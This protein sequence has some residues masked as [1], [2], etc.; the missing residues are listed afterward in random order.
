MAD[1]AITPTQLGRNAG[2]VAVSSTS[3]ATIV[4][5]GGATIADCD[6]DK[7]VLVF[8][9][10]AAATKDVTAE[11]GDSIYPAVRSGQ[12]DLVVTMGANTGSAVLAG[13]DS[14]R[15]RKADGSLRFTLASGTTGT[16]KAFYLP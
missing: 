14:G 16:V 9:N 5:A 1:T 7:L 3:L 2:T 4:S 15:F 11:A 10:T 8:D 6:V 13:L 12:G